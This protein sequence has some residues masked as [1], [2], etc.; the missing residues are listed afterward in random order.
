MYYRGLFT[1]FEIGGHTCVG[2]AIPA[3]KQNYYPAPS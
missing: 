2:S 3:K 1:P